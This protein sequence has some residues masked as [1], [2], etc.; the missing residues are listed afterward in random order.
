[1]HNVNSD[2][3]D[4]VVVM[5]LDRIDNNLSYDKGILTFNIDSAS[6]DHIVNT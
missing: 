6:F 5:N 4:D 1:M 3:D 2:R